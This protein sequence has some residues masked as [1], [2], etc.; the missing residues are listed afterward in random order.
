VKGEQPEVGA[1]RAFLVTGQGY[2]SLASW[3]EG[4]E[5][6]TPLSSLSTV[7]RYRSLLYSLLHLYPQAVDRNSGH[8]IAA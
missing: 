3:Q 8:R 1:R 6:A 5:E 7:H 4:S 2:W